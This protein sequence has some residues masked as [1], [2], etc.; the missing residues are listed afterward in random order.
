[1]CFDFKPPAGGIGGALRLGPFS[2]FN[3]RRFPRPGSAVA[4][5]VSF[6]LLLVRVLIRFIVLPKLQS[7]V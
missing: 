1:M 7:Y 3:R 4:P 6:S 2:S 5:R